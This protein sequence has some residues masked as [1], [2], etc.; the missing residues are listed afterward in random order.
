MGGGE[1]TLIEHALKGIKVQVTISHLKHLKNALMKFFS[2]QESN[3]SM[4]LQMGGPGFMFGS[5][6]SINLQFDD[7]EELQ[8]HPLASNLMIEFHALIDQLTGHEQEY[9]EN[10]KE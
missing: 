8:Q 1:K 6:T 3:L 5:D 9:Y 2:E 10:W 4:M 7:I